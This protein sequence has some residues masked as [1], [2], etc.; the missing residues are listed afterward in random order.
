M[1]WISGR[2]SRRCWPLWP[3]CSSLACFDKDCGEHRK[4]EYAPTEKEKTNRKKEREQEDA[5]RQKF[6]ASIATALGKVKWPLSEA[7]RRAVRH[8]AFRNE[9]D[10]AHAICEAA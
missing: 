4:A 7:S 10:R 1:A 9:H 3:A 6:D 5:K 8:H 2:T